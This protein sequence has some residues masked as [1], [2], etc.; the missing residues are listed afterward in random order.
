MIQWR[1]L[2]KVCPKGPSGRR[3]E[4]TRS[5]STLP[6]WDTCPSQVTSQHFVGCPQSNLAGSHLYTWVERGTLRVKCFVRTRR[7][8]TGRSSNS[9]P[10]ERKFERYSLSLLIRVSD[11][12]VKYSTTRTKISKENKN[13]SCPIFF[14]ILHNY[15]EKG[16]LQFRPEYLKRQK[17]HRP[18]G[19]DNIQQRFYTFVANRIFSDLQGIEMGIRRK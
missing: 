4:A 13:P 5:I 3:Y 17:D 16:L 1:V 14:A 10:P 6:G 11:N 9:R 8:C 2:G 7:G 18:M 12:P 19:F 15:K